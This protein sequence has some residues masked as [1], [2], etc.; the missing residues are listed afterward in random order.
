MSFLLFRQVLRSL[1]RHW[2]VKNSLCLLKFKM[3]KMNKL[4]RK[5]NFSETFFRYDFRCS[6]PNNHKDFKRTSGVAIV[7]YDKTKGCLLVI[8]RPLKL[9][10]RFFSQPFRFRLVHNW[11]D[12]SPSGN[13]F[14]NAF[15]NVTFKSKTCSRNWKSFETTWSS[16]T[17]RRFSSSSFEFECHFQRVM[18]TQSAKFLEKFTI[19]SELM[20]LAIGTHGSNLHKA[21]EIPGV[22]NIEVEDENCTIKISGDVSQ[23]HFFDSIRFDSKIWFQTE[24]AV[25]E[26]RAIMEYV[27]DVVTIPRD[28]IGKSQRTN[29][30]LHF[31]ENLFFFKAKLSAKKVTSFKKSLIKVALFELKSKVITI[32]HHRRQI[33]KS[34][35][36]KTITLRHL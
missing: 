9:F 17:E 28:M 34:M 1:V 27:E 8:V 19:K 16:L 24:K 32:N 3:C 15:S 25:K 23:N 36:P 7:R 22:T 33:H 35:R 5:R 18:I 4:K 30:E 20:G 6:N 13:S 11:C 21:R 10:V 26:A 2:D 14:R 29:I 31:N 12:T